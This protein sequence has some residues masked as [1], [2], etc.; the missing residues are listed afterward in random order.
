MRIT[1]AFTLSLSLGAALAVAGAGYA[2]AAK[3]GGGDRQFNGL[4][5]V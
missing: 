1:G 3:K 4:I 2:R 5:D